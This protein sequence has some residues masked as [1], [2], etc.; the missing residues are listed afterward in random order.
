MHQAKK[1]KANTLDD[2][3]HWLEKELSLKE[4]LAQL[5]QHLWANIINSV[6]DIWPSIQVIFEQNDLAKESIEEIQK[7]KADLGK[8]P[9]EAS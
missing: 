5:K 8:K 2:R 6:N 4:P 7:V 9:N 1:Q 3:I